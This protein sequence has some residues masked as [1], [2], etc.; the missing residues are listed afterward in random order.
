MR[1]WVGIL[2]LQLGSESFQ[3]A[4]EAW[5]EIINIPSPERSLFECHEIET[6]DDPEVVRSTFQ[7]DPKVLVL[8]SIRIQDV[9]SGRDNLEID[10]VVAYKPS[11]GRNE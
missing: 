4:G 8:F 7:S 3:L 10:D 1:L 11:A 6:C 5:W 9:A 2:F